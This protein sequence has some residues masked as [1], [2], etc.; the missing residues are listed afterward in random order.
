MVVELKL[1]KPKEFSTEEKV[2]FLMGLVLGDDKTK[3]IVQ[4]IDGLWK[5]DA[6]GNPELIQEGMRQSHD[7]LM[8]TM[9]GGKQM[10]GDGTKDN[11]VTHEG[12]VDKIQQLI[13]AQ[14]NILNQIQTQ[15][16]MVMI[17]EKMKAIQ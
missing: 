6:K 1:T 13:T 7:K 12:A 9:Y 14:N 16:K 3:G 5:T 8:V 15:E 11:Y 2:N 4:V 17:I 10:I